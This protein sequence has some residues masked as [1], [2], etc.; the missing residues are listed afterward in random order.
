MRR[1]KS[2]RLRCGRVGK[3]VDIMVAVALGV[4]DADQCAKREVLLH[5][6]AGLTGQVLA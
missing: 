3:A 5:A 6:E 4:G 2:L 1:E